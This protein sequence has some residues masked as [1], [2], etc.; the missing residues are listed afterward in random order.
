MTWYDVVFAVFFFTLIKH[1]VFLSL[2]CSNVAGG[3]QPQLLLLFVLYFNKFYY[4]D[5]TD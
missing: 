1:S 3:K 5:S 4:F 2:H